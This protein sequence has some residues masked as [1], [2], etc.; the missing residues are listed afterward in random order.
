MSAE[1]LDVNGMRAQSCGAIRVGVTNTKSMTK[2][3]LAEMGCFTTK[4]FEKRM[5]VGFYG[6]TLMYKFI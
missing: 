5:V 1:S 4:Q 2:P 6:G 3:D